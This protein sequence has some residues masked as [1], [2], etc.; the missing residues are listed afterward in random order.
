MKKTFMPL[1]LA[2]L[3][4]VPVLADEGMW[5]L[6]LLKEQHTID[7]MKQAGLQLEADD[8]YRSDSISLKDAVGIFGGGCTGEI[9]SPEGLI[10]TNH[11]CGY[12]SLQK[13]STLEHD[14]LK[15]GFWTRSKE[16]ELPVPGLSFTFVIHIEDLT[17]TVEQDI[18]QG[19]V[20]EISALQSRYLDEVAEAW[21]TKSEYQ[22]KAGFHPE[23]LPYFAGNK[24]YLVVYQVYSDVRMVGAPPS[25]IGKFGGETD[26]WMWPRHTGDFSLFRIYA[27][28][29]GN[30]ARYSDTNIPLHPKKYLHLSVQGYEEGDYAMIMGFP[31]STDRYLTAAEVRNRVENENTPRIAVREMRQSVLKE[32]MSASDS[33]RIMYANKYAS[34][35]NY[36][37]N[38]I[39]M[40]KAIV[41]NQ[42][43]EK[44]QQQE[45]RFRLF[46]DSVGNSAYK[47]AISR[48]S[49]LTEEQGKAD[50]DATLFSEVFLS[51]L[52]YSLLL[53]A[54]NGQ[55]FLDI[56][57]NIVEEQSTPTTQELIQPVVSAFERIHNK[58]YSHEVDKAV[59]NELLYLYYDLSDE[60]TVLPSFYQTVINKYK[61]K[62]SQY[63]DALYNNSIFSSR[64]NL[65]AFLRKPT[66]K[67]LANDP[68]YLHA[69]SLMEKR[70]G[71]VAQ[72]QSSAS[73]LMQLQKTYVRGLTE[74]N[75][76][77]PQY[78][79][80]NFTQRLTY[81]NVRPYNPADGITYRHYTTLQGVLD[82][83]DPTNAEFIVPAALSKLAIAQD[84]GRYANR[85]GELPVCFLMTGDITGGNSGSPVLDAKG[86][87][88]G[89]AFDGNWESLSGDIEFDAAKQRCICVDIRYILFIID[90][91]AGCQ[92]LINELTIE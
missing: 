60:G 31:G 73:D 47:E 91:F 57:Q 90:K 33:L 25:S 22:G 6:Q 3:M 44:K 12:S 61:G 8:L 7:L 49:S 46:A 74:M 59:A 26:N 41:K 20:D 32:Y 37:K 40:N 36:W 16:E 9:I 43:V 45:A 56:L 55:S 52:E 82:K 2:W 65:E 88:I 35:S 67:T 48:I 5:L 58:D 77:K 30:P 84:Y 80:A 89:A 69:E 10:L 15:D 38:S 42:T 4:S 71:I 27:D 28:T 1:V 81:G 86:R 83:E 85:Q 62:T 70:I 68:L 39:G 17:D 11:H 24:Y 78:P 79:D 21:F 92:N 66:V 63:V 72:L 87:L 29:D 64:K 18:R 34:S 13:L 53:R 54:S 76:A 14:Y 75:A 23:L 19:K 51:A 50:Y